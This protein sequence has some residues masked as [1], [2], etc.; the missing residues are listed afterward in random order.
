VTLDKGGFADT[1]ITDKNELELGDLV[2][3]LGFLLLLGR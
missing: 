3:G 2:A 1:T